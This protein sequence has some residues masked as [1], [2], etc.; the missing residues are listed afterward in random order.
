M[1]GAGSPRKHTARS[2][3]YEDVDEGPHISEE[4]CG[5]AEGYEE[6]LHSLGIF[7]Q[8]LSSS[9]RYALHGQDPYR[10]D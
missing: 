7:H 9:W 4:V 2:D 1:V 3:C 5:G 8:V 6:A 10:N